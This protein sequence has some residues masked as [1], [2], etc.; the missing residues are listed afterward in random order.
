MTALRTV[1]LEK[2]T[3]YHRFLLLFFSRIYTHHIGYIKMVTQT[4]FFRISEQIRLVLGCV[5]TGDS[6]IEIKILK[7]IEF[8]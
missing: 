2:S 4:F 8:V 5:V 3:L 1:Q 6:Y 7:D